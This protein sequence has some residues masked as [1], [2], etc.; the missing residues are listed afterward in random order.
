VNNGTFALFVPFRSPEEAEAV[1]RN[2]VRAMEH[3]LRRL[4]WTEPLSEREQQ[5]FLTSISDIRTFA[6]GEEIV[7]A[8]RPVDFSTIILEGL[9]CRQ[10]VLRTGDR[11]ITAFHLTGDFC[12]L[13]TYLVKSLPDSVVGIT[14]CRVAVVPHER[15]DKLTSGLPRVARLLWKS[16]LI[17][18]S[19]Y[20]R[21]LVCIG[22]Q[23]ALSRLAHLFCEFYVRL[24]VVGIANGLTFPLPVTQSDLSDAMGMSLVHTNR[25][26][27][28]LRARN[29]ATFAQRQVM[30]HNW[31]RL[32]E[33]AEFDPQYLH[34]G[35]AV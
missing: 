12:D 17:D 6:P 16:T 29:L 19:V 35:Q 15:L 26:C 25:T 10:K 28:A 14:A 30:I 4:E 20:R 33:A 2:R 21:W 34:V 9:A 24:K 11:Q 23:S 1:V 32:R 8:H 22:R 5:Q 31:E 7:P 3:L 18:A 13:H 27:A